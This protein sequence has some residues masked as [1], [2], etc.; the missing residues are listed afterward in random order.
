MK[1]LKSLNQLLWLQRS[2]VR[3]RW[4]FLTRFWG[5]DIAKSSVYSMSVK[6]DRTHPKGIHIGED[7]YVAFDVAILSH[8][9]VRAMKVDTYIGDNCFIGA[10]S[11][12]LPGVKV[13]NGSIVGSGS[14][15]TKDVPAGS[16]VAGNP[17]KVLQSNIKVGR[18]G[19]LIK[20]EAA[21]V[22]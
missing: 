22:A 15:V 21:K 17:A 10:R 1:G 7:S 11:I 18:F 13:G 3:M 20:E 9:M 4:Y 14:V 16:I 19:V 8:D 2:L 12:I 5:M 6:F